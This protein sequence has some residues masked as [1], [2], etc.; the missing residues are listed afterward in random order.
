MG[1]LNEN[2]RVYSARPI[3]ISG[4]CKCE[5]A[6][7][8]AELIRIILEAVRCKMKETSISAEVTSV[9]SDGETRRGGALA[10]LTLK[11]PL[12]ET[13]RIYALLHPLMFMN[14]RV[15]NQDLTADKDYRHL[16]KRLRNL[17]LRLRGI[18]IF[19]QFITTSVLRRHLADEGLSKAH[20]DAIFCP[21]DRQ[22]V[23]LAYGLLKDTWSLP[24]KT[25]D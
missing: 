14:L 11:D 3:L 17:L 18:I 25:L 7:E 21:E 22:D 24:H 19:S 20:L 9:A 4:T 23:E 2:K 12:P 16:F 6:P 5:K 13:S 10:M 15:G 8:H 1:L